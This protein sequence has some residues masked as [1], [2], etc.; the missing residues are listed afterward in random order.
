M[1]AAPSAAA[2]ATATSPFAPGIPV[3]AP[4]ARGPGTSQSPRR[5]S[6]AVLSAG[7]ESAAGRASGDPAPLA[8][9]GLGK[10]MLGDL[11][12]P[13]GKSALAVAQVEAP[14]AAEALVIS[15]LLEP[16]GRGREP[17]SPGRERADVVHRHVL[18]IERPHVG[19]S[20]DA[21]IDHLE[22]GQAAA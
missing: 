6:S 5:E 21:A 10:Q 14:E 8:E 4:T 19:L 7:G 20:S 2:A 11:D 18:D 16:L 22:R 13:L 1:L 3:S 15:E 17:H 12:A 9:A